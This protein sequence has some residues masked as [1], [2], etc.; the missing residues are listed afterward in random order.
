[1]DT[2]QLKVRIRE[3]TGVRTAAATP[4]SEFN[5]K[6]AGAKFDEI[7]LR[8]SGW[9]EVSLDEATGNVWYERLFTLEGRPLF[10]FRV[11]LNRLG[12][13]RDA[14]VMVFDP[15][16][17][18]ARVRTRA[19]TIP[20]AVAEEAGCV[21]EAVRAEAA[22]A[23]MHEELDAIL[24]TAEVPPDQPA[25]ASEDARIAKWRQRLADHLHSKPT[26]ARRVVSGA[27]RHGHFCRSGEVL[28]YAA[29][30]AA[31]LGMNSEASGFVGHALG[32]DL[33]NTAEYWDLLGCALDR[34]GLPGEAFECFDVAR[35]MVPENAHYRD[36]VWAVGRNLLPV[37]LGRR[38][39]TGIVRCTQV[40]LDCWQ[41]VSPV[42][43]SN[44]LCA[45][46]LG[47]EGKGD[48][49]EAAVY[50]NLAAETFRE[51][52]GAEPASPDAEEGAAAGFC[53]M[54]VCG[55]HR[56]ADGDQE[57]RREAF[58][59]QVACF[60]RTPA[61]AGWGGRAPVTH[62]EEKHHGGHW[63]TLVE[64][65][66]GFI[67][68]NLDALYEG[69]AVE[70]QMEY[71]PAEIAYLNFDRAQGRECPLGTPDP[72]N[73][74]RAFLIRGAEV[75]GSSAPIVSCF[76]VF[77]S[78]SFADLTMDRVYEY[79]SGLE[80][81]VRMH[82]PDAG[83]LRFFVPD[84][85]RDRGHFKQN[86]SY[87]VE[88]AGFAY[89]MEPFKEQRWQITEG[90]ALEQEKERLRAAGLSDDISSFEVVMKD[91]AS[92]LSPRMDSEHGTNCDFVGRVEEVTSF[93]FL[94]KRIH[95]VVV[96]FRPDSPD[97]LRL[98][99]FVGEHRLEGFVPQAGAVVRG[100]LWLQGILRAEIG[101]AAAPERNLGILPIFGRVDWVKDTAEDR[102]PENLAQQALAVLR[103]EEIAW[104]PR[105]V[106]GDPE[107][108]VRLGGRNVFLHL[109]SG[110]V[111]DQQGLERMVAD[112]AAPPDA[113]GQTRGVS[114]EHVGIGLLR[115]G[116]GFKV[117][118]T[119]FDELQE[120]CRLTQGGQ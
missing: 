93:D 70:G 83:V 27:A 106:S 79:A 4:E 6:Y 30:A 99:I 108:V 52:G 18:P 9:R 80:A 43:K 76:P 46:A 64:D 29:Y 24:G 5:R 63:G 69:S 60:P 110:E 65:V 101:P 39:F 15:E 85:Y 58:E 40:M 55:L 22:P 8:N 11:C 75:G 23:D 2:Q 44:C 25:A 61:E 115:Q 50:F 97:S 33:A 116:E 68:G 20:P 54:A 107:L 72:A 47:Y 7:A 86:Y 34:L 112:A 118:Y 114:L 26:L 53:T 94:G 87:R 88:L 77:C 73:G 74:L 120:K 16:A 81:D 17:G 59:A 113:F 100:S 104:I 84:Y 48:L 3:A 57:R 14:H 21:F 56:L 91:D 96:H 82:A 38:D 95:R 45:L 89:W 36:N 105:V 102:A 31:E 42:E 10:E 62:I 71:P 35:E 37:L 78:G 13:W 111:A 19:T 66:A 119:G 103:P 117:L 28:A 32:E 109:V 12:Y 49:D 51:K 92:M 41:A 90:P 98:P 1:V 67:E